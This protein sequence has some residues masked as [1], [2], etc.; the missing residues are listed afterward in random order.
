MSEDDNED[1]LLAMFEREIEQVSAASAAK[2]AAAKDASSTTPV[3]QQ[4]PTVAPRPSHYLPQKPVIH[5]QQPT[6]HSQHP[7]HSS[8]IP[9]HVTS[10]HP[11]V[12]ITAIPTVLPQPP[13]H[14]QQPQPESPL[15]DEKTGNETEIKS[16]SII[17][18]TAAGQVWQDATLEEWP[19]DDHRLF[20]GDLGPDATDDE[21]TTA[22]SKYSSFNMAR[23][24]KDKRTSN[25]RGY[26]FVSFGKAAD[27]L[28]AIR[29]MNGKY[30]GSRPVKLRRSN[31]KKRSLTKDKWKQVHA[32]R[33]ISKHR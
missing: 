29:E 16:K 1:D 13:P 28:A 26:G 22:F 2:A 31:W 23:V 3:T 5:P 14:Q 19:E 9:Y 6:V 27:M 17:K 33:S 12:S 7:P 20:V 10:N 32:F 8:N 25:C 21:L 4:A 15:N 18:R 11:I 24:V 30:V